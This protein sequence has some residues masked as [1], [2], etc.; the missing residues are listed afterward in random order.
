M[1]RPLRFYI[2]WPGLFVYFL[3]NSH[4]TRVIVRCRGE[5]LLVRDTAR[6]GFDS[7]RWTL[8]GGG[9]KQGEEDT[10]AAVR[11]LREELGM[12]VEP[13]SLVLLGEQEIHSDGLGYTAQYFLVDIIRK[14]D[15][16]LDRH[17]LS[18][19]EWFAI[20][21]AHSLA[22]KSELEVGLRLLSAKK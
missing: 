14:P 20:V 3:L 8:P 12:L 7:T 9:I 19:A 5:V 22:M 6:Y 15:I 2:F 11:E 18:E 10:V 1:S 21:D 4:R 16:K 13:D 17:E